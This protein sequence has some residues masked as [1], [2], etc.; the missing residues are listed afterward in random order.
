MIKPNEMEQIKEILKSGFEDLE[1]IA[2]EYEIPLE[3]VKKI[4]R[5]IK[6]NQEKSNT[7]FKLK[8]MRE[9]YNALFYKIYNEQAKGKRELNEAEIEEI[10]EVIAEVSKLIEQIGQAPKE[11]KNGIVSKIFKQIRKIETYTLTIDQLEQLNSL[12]QSE[13]LEG[14]KSRP[15]DPIE[16]NINKRRREIIDKLAKAIEIQQSQTE[17]LEELK[18][19]QK[20]I[21]GQMVRTSQIV[22]G[23]VKSRIESKIN[24]IKEKQASSVTSAELSIPIENIIKGLA[25]GELDIERAVEAVYEETEKRNLNKAKTKFALTP[26]QEQ[27][28]ILAQIKTVLK[29][30]SKD[31]PI[32]NPYATVELLQELSKEDLEYSINTVVCNLLE[33]KEFEKAKELCEHYSDDSDLQNSFSQYVYRLKKGIRNAEIGDMVMKGI[34][35]IGSAEE[36]EKYFELIEKGIK[37]AN[38]KLSSISLGRSQDGTRNITLADIWYDD[39]YIGVE[40]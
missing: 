33:Q 2:F 22:A 15:T 29:K 34:D 7:N 28:R 1:L 12:M 31:F 4:K 20:K 6:K 18:M 11:E 38:I 21:T 39:R 9:K 26:E 17:D 36:Q 27:K 25:N 30:N 16:A 19:L 23:G 10:N 5:E 24:R 14:L 37:L 32:K 8:K 35:M 13:R 3:Y 40:K